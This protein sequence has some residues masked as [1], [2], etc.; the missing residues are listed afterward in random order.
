MALH[1]NTL[2]I[3][4]IALILGIFVARFMD[5]L[6]TPH[7][8]GFILLG[9]LLGDSFLHLIPI[10]TVEA[11][12]PITDMALGFIGFGMGEHL[13]ISDLRKLGKSFISIALLESLGAYTLVFAG[14]YIFSRSIPMAM[15]IASLASATDPAAT[16]DVLKQYQAEGPLT[17]ILLAV[18][19]IDDAIA[20]LLYSVSAPIALS[21]AG[22][23]GVLS[24]SQVALPLIEIL[25]SVILGIVCAYPVDFLID[26]MDNNEE[27]L[28]FMISSV[29]LVV[30]V[31]IWLNLSVILA[32]LVF[33]ATTINLKHT[34]AEHVSK[35][36]DRVS[37]ILYILFFVLVGARLDINLITDV[38]LVALAYLV[39][40]AFGKI[41]GAYL[42]ARISNSS[43]V[44]QK[45]LGMTLLP[46]AGVAVGLALS[47]AS[48]V[49]N[50]GAKG[51]IIEQ[52]IITTIIATTLV[53]QLIGPILTKQAIFRAGEVTDE[54]GTFFG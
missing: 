52:T 31:S 41:S 18:V 9:V 45:Y 42:G 35:T 19:G 46:Q 54:H 22:V 43:A 4:G 21:F 23:T 14:V 30:G 16:V 53:V 12:N 25:G 13:L 5:E 15:I 51:A 32:S 2:L 37:P 29:L 33:G 17:T 44:V 6:S 50:V 40:R 3:F 11:L 36:I 8:V 24:I 1:P 47:I 20:L 49:S 38:G 27:I 39:F 48:K 34:H 7:V 28:L 10:S 26:R